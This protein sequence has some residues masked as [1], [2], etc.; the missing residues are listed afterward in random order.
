MRVQNRLFIFL[1]VLVPLFFGGTVAKGSDWTHHGLLYHLEQNAAALNA[2]VKLLVRENPQLFQLPAGPG[3]WVVVRDRVA[4]IPQGGWVSLPPGA[5]PPRGAAIVP[6]DRVMWSG[7]WVHGPIPYIIERRAWFG[8]PA[9]SYLAKPFFDGLWK[10]PAGLVLSP[11]HPEYIKAEIVRRFNEL[12]ASSSDLKKWYSVDYLNWTRNPVG[13]RPNPADFR[14]LF[15]FVVE[16]SLANSYAIASVLDEAVS[17]LFY[18]NGHPY[19]YPDNMYQKRLFYRMGAI[20]YYLNQTRYLVD[21]IQH[22]K[23]F[24]FGVVGKCFADRYAPIQFRLNTGV[25]PVVYPVFPDY[26]GRYPGVAPLGHVGGHVEY[27]YN[28]ERW[29][30]PGPNFNI[31]AYTDQATIERDRLAPR[32]QED[33]WYRGEYTGTQ[34]PQNRLRPDFG[35]NT[36]GNFEDGQYQEFTAPGQGQ[37]QGNFQG[38]GQQPSYQQPGYPQG[39]GTQPGYPQGQP[40]QLPYAGPYAPGRGPVGPQQGLPGQV[41]PGQSN[42]Y[43]AQQQ[44]QPQTQPQSQGQGPF[45]TPDDAQKQLYQQQQNQNPPERPGQPGAQVPGTPSNSGPETQQLPPLPDPEG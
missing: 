34:I 26:N 31:P 25:R 16:Q 23:G 6:V 41:Y 15:H 2:E 20:Q 32:Y 22:F 36:P 17:S 35:G 10:T 3:R 18:A 1:A 30:Y 19:A 14:Q 5:I 28:Q 27:Q 29:Q 44:T 7:A 38:P 33:P 12:A 4:V 8:P 24:G 37:G 43:S 11:R 39:P 42:P 40:G 45:I 21:T 9:T 13:P